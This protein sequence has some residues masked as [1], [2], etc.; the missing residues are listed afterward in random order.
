MMQGEAVID[1]SQ[2]KGENNYL[3][4]FTWWIHGSKGTEY[5]YLMNSTFMGKGIGT[6]NS[7]MWL[8]MKST[9]LLY[10]E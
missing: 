10:L 5:V 6:N 2:S 1:P 8:Y 9:V 4:M 3:N 7:F